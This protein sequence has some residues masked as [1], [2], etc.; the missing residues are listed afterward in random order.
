M[1]APGFRA[2]SLFRRTV[3][4]TAAGLL[5]YGI[6][7]VP[8][9]VHLE[10]GREER[11]PAV[12]AWQREDTWTADAAR[13]FVWDRIPILGIRLG[14]RHRL[15]VVDLDTKAKPGE[16][17]LPE[18]SWPTA[19]QGLPA[20]LEVRTPSGGRHRYYQV[21]EGVELPLTDLGA[22]PRTTLHGAVDVLC[23]L[24]SGPEG[25]ARASMIAAPPS[26]RPGGTYTVAE[27]HPIATLRPED[28]AVLEASPKR[29]AAGST[30]SD[31]AR[32]ARSSALPP[33][34]P[35]VQDEFSDLIRQAGK[36]GRAFDPRR[37][38]RYRCP[39]HQGRSNRSL[40]VDPVAAVFCC[41]SPSCPAAGGGGLRKLRDLLGVPQPTRELEPE[42]D[43]HQAPEPTD[44]Q[45]R[46][47]AADQ[48]ADW[49]APRGL[50]VCPNPRRPILAEESPDGDLTGGMRVAWAPCEKV[51]CGHCGPKILGRWVDHVRP[52]VRSQVP[53]HRTVLHLGPD[54]EGARGG[55][56]SAWSTVARA[57]RRAG[58]DY[59][60]IRDADG[61]G[62]V[63]LYSAGS[64]GFIRSLARLSASTEREESLLPVQADN[65]PLERVY[66]DLGRAR[67]VRGEAW[68]RAVTA[69]GAWRERPPEEGVELAHPPEAKYVPVGMAQHR[70]ADAPGKLRRW[71]AER[72][73]PT[74]LGVIRHGTDSA[75]A[76]TWRVPSGEDARAMA[77][78][79]STY[80]GLRCA[81][82]A[83]QAAGGAA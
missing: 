18:G 11:I 57:L 27:D 32:S 31:R 63:V 67:A 2:A 77:R 49:K 17:E 40:S 13:T 9:R 42:H 52:A 22:W 16:P 68:G 50:A 8:V 36:L 76:V 46:Q 58:V 37:A 21:P 3:A 29:T 78:E 15:L 54:V 61:P 74:R 75:A 4:D 66:E 60:A 73:V 48:A 59:L 25:D 83:R 14:G 28:L 62:S 45:R 30:G 10:D 55:T 7:P 56:T 24:R 70:A 19:L 26:R 47:L 6:V 1:T 65:S 23:A 12:T 72:G 53:V 80:D 5:A 33:A 69:G 39:F 35:A 38:A 20:T 82:W 44:E 51:T 79:L 81:R 71:L 43:Y 41:F 64:V 34:P